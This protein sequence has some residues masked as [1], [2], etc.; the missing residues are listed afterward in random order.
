MY[1]K[2]IMVIDINSQYVY[3]VIESNFVKRTS[4]YQKHMYM[5]NIMQAL[6]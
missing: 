1:M 2:S 4:E 6:R 3:N 5:K